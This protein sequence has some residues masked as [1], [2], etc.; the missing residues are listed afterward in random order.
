[1]RDARRSRSA[2]RVGLVLW[3]GTGTVLT[4]L[5]VLIL[6]VIYLFPMTYMVFTALKPDGQFTDTRAPIWPAEVVTVTYEGAEYP[7]Y[8]VPTEKGTQQWALITRRR[9]QSEFYDPAHPE[10]GLITWDGRWRT[11]EPAYRFSPAFENLTGLFD[12]AEVA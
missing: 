7:V 11:L 8:R 9:E 3:D 1:M 5:L 10:A 12:P 6:I 4:N 2:F